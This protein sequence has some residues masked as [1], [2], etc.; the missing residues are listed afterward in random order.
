MKRVAVICETSGKVR[1]AFRKRGFHA[2]S[3]DLL[4]SVDN[5]SYHFQTDAIT[6]LQ[7]S[8]PFDL[9]V[10]HPTCTYLCNSGVCWLH[11]GKGTRT[12]KNYNPTQCNLRWE[13]LY[14]AMEFFNLLRER[15]DIEHIALEN[16]IPHKY[17]V[18][19][20]KE[21]PWGIGKYTQIIQPYQFGHPETKATCLW[22]KN[23]PK[24]EPTNIV[25]LPK[26]RKKRMRLHYLPPGPDRWKIRS[27]TFQ[28]IADAMAKQWG[29]YIESNK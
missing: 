22:L 13:K 4:P 3:V 20:T 23:L 26:D 1:E 25:K 21:F 27:E 29:D 14:E 2:V 28:G 11:P 24:L 18:Y 17:A 10:A 6:F 19:G 12:K 9:M 16:P 7:T 8:A 5:S 15:D